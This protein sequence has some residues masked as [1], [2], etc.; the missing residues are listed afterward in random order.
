MARR[1]KDH[2]TI[3]SQI[4]EWLTTCLISLN[5]WRWDRWEWLNEKKGVEAK[6]C[7]E[8]ELMKMI[9][10]LL[11][12]IVEISDTDRRNRVYWSHSLI[13]RRYSHYCTSVQTSLQFII[14]INSSETNANYGGIAGYAFGIEPLHS[15]VCSQSLSTIPI[16][17]LFSFIHISIQ[18]E[19]MIHTDSN[20]REKNSIETSQRVKHTGTN[21]TRNDLAS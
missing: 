13:F 16:I 12:F 4:G 2:F 20:E 5:I 6:D 17:P 9:V 14:H 3:S 8:F 18:T 11:I 1:W 10:P 19:M 15:S 21:S 7:D